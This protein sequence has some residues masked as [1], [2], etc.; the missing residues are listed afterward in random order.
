[1]AQNRQPL[2]ASEKFVERMKILQRKIRMKK[3]DEVSMRKLT[4][5]I[6]SMPLFND[7]ENMLLNSDKKISMDINIKFDRRLK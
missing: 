1:M 4:E 7:I 2:M 3:G 6:I 5:D